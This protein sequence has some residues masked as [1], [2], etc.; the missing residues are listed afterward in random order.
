MNFNAQF[1]KKKTYCIWTFFI[2]KS[3][4]YALS[5][6]RNNTRDLESDKSAGGITLAILLGKRNA[7]ILYCLLL[8][9]PYAVL[10]FLAFN[11][12]WTLL[13]PLVTVPLA[14]G[15]SAKCFRGDLVMIPQGTAQL[16]L[17]FGFLYLTGLA[18]AP[19]QS[20]FTDSKCSPQ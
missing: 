3:F 17:L 2:A 10:G 16:N 19:W 5:F 8:M 12:S 14:V 1:R 15:L 13:L 9:I 7:C 4:A 11:S 20:S 6:F 18:L